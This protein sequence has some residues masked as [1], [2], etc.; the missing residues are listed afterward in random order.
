[1]SLID[2]TI[3]IFEKV[4]LYRENSKWGSKKNKD[5]HIQISIYC[6]QKKMI[7]NLLKVE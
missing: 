2:N 7:E 1:L 3:C 5:S 6:D 4:D